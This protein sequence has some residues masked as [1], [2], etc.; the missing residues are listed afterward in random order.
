MNI[1]RINN[2]I[3]RDNKNRSAKMRPLSDSEIDAASMRS[4]TEKPIK[5]WVSK[6]FLASLWIDGGVLRLSVNKTILNHNG[7]WEDGI[8]WDELQQVKRECG[9]SDV[10]AVEIYPPD[11]DVVNDANIRHL[12]LL[13][14]SPNFVWGAENRITDGKKSVLELLEIYED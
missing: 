14:K 3:K 12:W 9:F 8:T 1:Q 11:D 4:G 13:S 5:S 6:R 7:T 2:Q 10:C